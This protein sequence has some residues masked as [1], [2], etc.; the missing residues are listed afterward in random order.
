MLLMMLPTVIVATAPI[1][2]GPARIVAAPTVVL[3]KAVPTLV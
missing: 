3:A 1:K 2:T